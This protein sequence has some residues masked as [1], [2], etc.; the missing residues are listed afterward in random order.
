MSANNFLL[1]DQSSPTFFRSTGERFLCSWCAML[2]SAFW[3]ILP[4]FRLWSR[5]SPERL[6]M[7]TIGK[8]CDRER[9]L[10]LSAKQARWTLVHYPE[11]STCE[12]GP[13][14]VDFF[15]DTISVISE[16]RDIRDQSRKL[17]KSEI[18]AK[19]GAVLL[20]YNLTFTPETSL[21]IK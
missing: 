14:Q 9:F 5:I 7:S 19:G 1:V 15:R 16:S 6:T 20:I 4:N 3:S 21:T 11:S 17:K 2:G 13:T 10:P 8:T 12:F 18:L